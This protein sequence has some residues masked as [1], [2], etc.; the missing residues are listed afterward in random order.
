MRLP[1]LKAKISIQPPKRIAD[2]IVYS[3]FAAFPAADAPEY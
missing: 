3:V 1:T 2:R